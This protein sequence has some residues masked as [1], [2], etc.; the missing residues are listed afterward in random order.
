MTASPT[1]ALEWSVIEVLQRLRW[2]ASVTVLII[3]VP[4]GLHN[5]ISGSLIFYSYNHDDVYINKMKLLSTIVLSTLCA[6]VCHCMVNFEGRK[7]GS[8]YSKGRLVAAS[9]A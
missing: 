2:S 7:V 6:R 9:R 1:R 3:P 4:G 8:H 5:G